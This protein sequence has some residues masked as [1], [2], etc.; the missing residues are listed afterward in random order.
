VIARTA[1]QIMSEHGVDLHVNTRVTA[2]EGEGGRLV[3]ARLSD[4]TVVETGLAVVAL[5]SIRNVEWLEGCSAVGTRQASGPADSV[6]LRGQL[7]GRGTCRTPP[8]AECVGTAGAWVSRP[9]PREWIA[10]EG[11]TGCLAVRRT[12]RPAPSSVQR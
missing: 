6:R 9:P 11:A 3:R 5:G 7:R 8:S 2:L 4:G 12:A 10:S 1:A